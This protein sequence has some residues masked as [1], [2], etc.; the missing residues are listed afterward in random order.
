MAAIRELAAVAREP[1]AGSAAARQG[2]SMLRLR[3]RLRAA[4]DELVCR[5]G[6]DLERVATQAACTVFLSLVFRPSSGGVPM[7]LL[8]PRADFIE[9]QSARRAED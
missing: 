7:P 5:A 1:D 8:P 4:A 6:S 3:V 2:P 9:R